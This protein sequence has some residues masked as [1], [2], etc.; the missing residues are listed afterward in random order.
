MFSNDANTFLKPNIHQPAA[1]EVAGK[2]VNGAILGRQKRSHIVAGRLDAPWY[3]GIVPLLSFSQWKTEI[4]CDM[5][6]DQILPVLRSE[7]LPLSIPALAD[8]VYTISMDQVRL[9]VT[10]DQIR[11][12][13]ALTQPM[14]LHF[15]QDH[16]SFRNSDPSGNCFLCGPAVHVWPVSI[17]GFPFVLVDPVATHLEWKPCEWIVLGA[18]DH[19]KNAE[20]DEQTRRSDHPIASPIGNFNMPCRLSPF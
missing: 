14:L 3:I 4:R 20:S 10:R 15:A 11:T 5:A 2:N 9:A 6:F 7:L 1:A 16:E 8:D 17:T 18:R 13:I 19:R 12:A